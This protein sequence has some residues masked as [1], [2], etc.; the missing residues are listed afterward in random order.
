MSIADQRALI[1]P[2]HPALSILRQCALVSISRSTFYYA[3][4]PMNEATLGLMRTIDEAFLEMPWPGDALVR[5]P[6]DGPAPAPARP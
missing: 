4:A 2:G 6:S 1:D 5:Q 3:P